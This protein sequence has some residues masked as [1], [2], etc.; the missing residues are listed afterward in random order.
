MVQWS[1]QDAYT[2]EVTSSS[3]VITT[4]L[5]GGLEMVPA[6]SHKPNDAGSNPVPATITRCI[7]GVETIEIYNTMLYHPPGLRLKG[8]ITVI[9]W[10]RRSMD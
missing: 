5:W 7:C 4:K 9:I 6:R 1:A 3:L 10:S 8:D 2:I